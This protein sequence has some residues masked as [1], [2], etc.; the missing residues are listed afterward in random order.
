MKEMHGF[1]FLDISQEIY[2][3]LQVI[4]MSIET[5]WPIIERCAKLGARFLVKKPLDTNTICNIWQYLDRKHLC[6][7]KIKNLF[8]G[9]SYFG[10][11]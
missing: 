10:D 1:E 11:L 6:M 5:T 2:K 4:M 7:E 9:Y 8:K 3:N